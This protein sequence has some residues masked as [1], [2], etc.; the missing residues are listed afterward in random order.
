LSQ[1]LSICSGTPLAR[2]CTSVVVFAESHSLYIWHYTYL[3]AHCKKHAH[4][5]T[6]TTTQ[7]R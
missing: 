4:I 3:S 1:H 7:E 2:H 6:M 5:I